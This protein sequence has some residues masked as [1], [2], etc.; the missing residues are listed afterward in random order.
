VIGGVSTVTLVGRRSLAPAFAFGV[1]LWGVSIVV[2]GLVLAPVPVV[3]MLAIAGFGLSFLDVSGRT[4]LQ[5]AVSDEALGRVF[6]VL[7]SGFMAAWGIGSVLAPVALRVLGARWTFA[8]A[9]ALLPTVTA[10]R[11]PRLV[12]VDDESPLPG[13]ELDLIREIDMFR[14]LPAA[15]LERLA[16][17]LKEVRKPAGATIMREGDP[18]DL[19]YVIADGEVSVT[20]KGVE[21]ARLGAG[22]YFGEIALLRDVPRTATVT[23]ITDVRL[24]G[25]ARRY[26]LE[27]VTGS[28]SSTAAA[29][30]EVG[31]RLA[32]QTLEDDA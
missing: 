30:D 14:P 16:R 2:I 25:L 28:T 18:G 32:A 26:F 9:G 15:V 23:A 20:K 4:L 19:F 1:A 8:V 10:L 22:S 7:E 17:H 3:A 29:D 21:I 27:A 11:S 12:R 13:P 24:M 6:G 31:R 5:R